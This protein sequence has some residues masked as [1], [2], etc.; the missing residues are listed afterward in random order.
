MVE[1]MSDVMVSLPVEIQV[2]ALS[3]AVQDV[4]QILRNKKLKAVDIKRKTKYSART[5]RSAL[6]ILLDLHLIYRSTDLKD[7]R[8]NFYQTLKNSN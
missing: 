7:L 5:I 8:S 6:K 1:K 4:Y 2:A 3:P